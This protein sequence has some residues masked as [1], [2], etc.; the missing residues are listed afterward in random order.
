[1]LLMVQKENGE[2]N[3][4]ECVYTHTRGQWVW[5]MCVSV[6]WFNIYRYINMVQNVYLQRM[7]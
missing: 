7:E 3:S 2:D 5:V 1:M 6:V 4:N